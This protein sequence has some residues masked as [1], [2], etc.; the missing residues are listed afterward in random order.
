MSDA[1]LHNTID[2]LPEDLKKQVMDFVEFLEAKS[3]AKVKKKD[4][5]F[6]CAKGFFKMSDNFDEP[7][8]DFKEYM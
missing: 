4:R 6:G 5:T 8:D 7:L 1:Q 3:Y 2:S